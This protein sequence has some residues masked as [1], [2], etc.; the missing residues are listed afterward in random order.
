MVQCFYESAERRKTMRLDP[1][2][3]S[4]LY[5]VRGFF[6]PCKR[7]FPGWGWIFPDGI[8]SLDMFLCFRHHEWWNKRIARG[9]VPTPE[10][11]L[12]KELM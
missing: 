11:N 9:R 5:G 4:I 1:C 10:S 7:K 6:V 12:Q 3:G 2:H 8:L